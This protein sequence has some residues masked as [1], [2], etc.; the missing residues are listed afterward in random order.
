MVYNAQWKYLDEALNA[1]MVDAVD[2]DAVI[3][4]PEMHDGVVYNFEGKYSGYYT[5]TTVQNNWDMDKNIRTVFKN[6][7]TKQI[8]IQNIYTYEQLIDLDGLENAY[9][10]YIT[11]CGDEV[12]D[13]IIADGSAEEMSDFEAGPFVVKRIKITKDN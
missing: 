11:G 13:E 4:F 8:E 2:N 3:I 1:A 6:K 9:F 7:N 5:A 12:A 10:F